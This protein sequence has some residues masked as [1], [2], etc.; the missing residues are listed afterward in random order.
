[1]NKK[2]VFI[3]MAVV[4][5]ISAIFSLSGYILFFHQEQETIILPS[6]NQ[7]VSFSKYE[8]QE[9]G[10]N[11]TPPNFRYSAEKTTP[12]VVHIRS[13]Y[14]QNYRNR[15]QNQGW[16]DLFRYFYD[17][18]E[19]PQEEPEEEQYGNI[20]SG[21]GVI[22][23]TDGYIITNNHVIENADKIEVVLSDKRKF[24]ARIIGTDIST[25]LGLLKIEEKNLNPIEYGNSDELQVGDWVLAVGNPF[26]LTST[27]T[28]GI[29]SA[30]GRNINLL[31]GKSGSYAI[32]SFIQTDAAV[33]PGN[34]GGALVNLQGQLIGI[35]TAIATQTGAYSGYS[36][37]VPASLVKK[38]IADLREF[39]T[40]QRGL[41]GVSIANINGDNYKE[42][43]VK[44]IEGVYVQDVNPNSG[45]DDSGIKKGD[46][47][48][49]INGRKVGTVA[50]LQE[51]VARN[52]PG[53]KIKVAI[54]RN[55]KIQLIDVV[56]KNRSNSLALVKASERLFIDVLGA[57]VSLINDEDKKN[58]NI[59]NG[60]KI[61]NIRQGKFRNYVTQG[62]IITH[63]DKKQ[64][65]SLEVFKQNL[66]SKK[67]KS[68]LVEGLYPDGTKAIYGLEL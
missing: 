13:Y 38:V 47:I 40:V 30:K 56:L 34:S 60:V 59:K 27:V 45:A 41:L 50:E 3:Y 28:A 53:D 20:G 57:E 48:L 5:F 9:S 25:D 46:V 54:K 24:E 26:N 31:R 8:N 51:L 52:R 17:L 18:E 33:N 39:G 43:G 58:L 11:S 44:K 65:S 2:R 66:E 55:D 15:R 22:I 4:A 6:E 63:I 62:F 42:L 16:E 23:S 61:L 67:G 7:K 29:V 49:S 37:A 1:M 68:I 32:E 12:T 10:L 64:V 19:P 35:N 36:F 14:K 21:S